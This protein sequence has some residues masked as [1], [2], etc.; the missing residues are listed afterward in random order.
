MERDS[1]SAGQ[2]SFYHIIRQN[3]HR[4]AHLSRNGTKEVP[5]SRELLLIISWMNRPRVDAKNQ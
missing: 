3:G 4:F 2:A 5:F 1:L